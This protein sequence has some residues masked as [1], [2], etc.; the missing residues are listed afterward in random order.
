MDRIEEVQQYLTLLYLVNA[1]TGLKELPS[2]PM[3]VC[4][5]GLMCVCGAR[6]TLSWVYECGLLCRLHLGLHMVQQTAVREAGGHVGRAVLHLYPPTGHCCKWQT[7]R[8]QDQTKRQMPLWILAGMISSVFTFLSDND[9]NVLYIKFTWETLLS[10]TF[11]PYLHIWTLLC[12]VSCSRTL[13]TRD[14]TA[15]PEI[16][17]LPTLPPELQLSHNMSMLPPSLGQTRRSYDNI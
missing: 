1:T 14:C 11:S 6:W 2:V 12:A 15:T 5:R 8:L 13:G 10:K 9:K 16:N 7:Q 3:P 4:F 17:G